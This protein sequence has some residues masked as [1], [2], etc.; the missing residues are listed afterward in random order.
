M[1][2]LPIPISGNSN[3][4]PVNVLTRHSQ[5]YE[6]HIL[7]YEW[8]IFEN[9]ECRE[10]YTLITN[11][12]E[13]KV[14][15]YMAPKQTVDSSVF[16]CMGF[17]DSD[18]QVKPAI[19]GTMVTF[20]WNEDIEKWDVC[21]RN[22]V[23]CNYS[24]M[25]PTFTSTTPV[26]T[27]RQMLMD[28]FR[29]NVENTNANANDIDDVLQLSGISKTYCF[30][31]I[32]QH[33][34]NHIVYKID[35]P[36]MKL[37]SIYERGSIPP[38]VELD[39]DIQYIY[40]IREVMNPQYIQM[41][42]DD[43]DTD[44]DDDC[45]LWRLSEKVFGRNSIPPMYLKNTEQIRSLTQKLFDTKFEED[46]IQ[47]DDLVEN[48]KSIYYPTAWIITNLRTG[49]KCE[50]ANPHYENAKIFRNMQPNL[51]YLYISL[52]KKNAVE[53]Y[54]ST[55]P[56]YINV[57]EKLGMEYEQFVTD[58]YQG[59]VK[60]YILKNRTEPIPKHHFVHAAR[61]HHELYLNPETEN[62]FVFCNGTLHTKR[63]TRKIV[64][65]YF[66]QFTPSKMFYFITNTK[67]NP[68]I[69]EP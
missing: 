6:Y 62:L 25:R 69:N 19:E 7:Q 49:Q 26:K 38:L 36:S 5:G 58:V 48:I 2:H 52:R 37:I 57:F 8:D 15:A 11:K 66:T 20:F 51:R 28:V 39:S 12:D 35:K 53:R 60:Y 3:K 61:I 55:F 14:F 63:V 59:Y 56:R 42:T 47:P 27:F 50:I 68:D 64:N 40:C 32:M 46:F 4:T 16:R 22:G 29:E 10:P 13:T 17:D 44:Y 18:M 1:F 9:G 41:N 45:F 21:T 24:F 30:T 23:G 43:T 31:C 34:E 67:T 65:E 54:L 33:P